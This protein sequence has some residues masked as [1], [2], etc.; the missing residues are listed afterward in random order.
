MKRITI[1]LIV[2]IGLFAVYDIFIVFMP[3]MLYVKS[4]LKKSDAILVLAGDSNGER[5]AHAVE[6]YK[7]GYAPKIVMSGGPAVWHLTYAEN[8]RRQA[9]CLGVPAKNVIIQDKS[10]STIQDIKYSLPVLKKMKVLRVILVTSPYHIKRSYLV[11]KKY[12][13]KEGIEVLASPADKTVFN[14]NKWWTRHEDTQFVIWEYV[15]IV[16]Y[17]LKGYLF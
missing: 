13:S 7:Q 5:V 15:A 8:M 16:Q 17:L 14:P 2:L 12:Y 1:I 9:T 3:S 11:A 4:D 6:L 10:K